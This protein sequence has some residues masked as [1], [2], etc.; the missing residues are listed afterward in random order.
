MKVGVAGLW[1]LGTV[2]AACCA[3][4]GHAVV[5]FDD[6][7]QVVNNLRQN[8]LPVDEPGLAELTR[9]EVEAGRLRFTSDAADLSESEVLWIAYDTPVNEEDVADVEYVNRRVAT[10]LP[11]LRNGA[12]VLISSQL[13]VGSTS[14][15]GQRWPELRFAY[16]P[17]NLRLGKAI[18]VFTKPD[19]VVVG[20]RDAE[21][22]ERL[23]P[24]F[25]PFTNKIEWMSIESAEMTKH[26]LNAFL[27]LSVTFINEVATICEKTGADAN[28]VE[29]GLKTDI[30]I[31][32]R[33]YLHAGSA[34]AG[35]TLARD[36]SFLIDVGE[37]RKIPTH[38]LQGARASNAEHKLWDRRLLSELLG[39]VDGKSVAILGLTYKPG[40][41][42]LRRSSSVETSRWLIA[43]GAAV[44]AF[45]P[46][47]TELP[48][49]L[50]AVRLS[51]SAEGALEGADAALIATPW[52]ELKAIP[53]AAFEKKMRRPLVL[54]PARHLEEVLKGEKG[55]EYFGIGASR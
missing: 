10:L 28:E 9:R 35:G 1:H 14:R 37:D 24:L 39:G 22:R 3:S 44:S 25:A 21:S 46:A 48:E 26:A 55:V 42:T 45:D 34:F 6:D 51:Q 12:L 38:L 5:A 2:T 40:T 36:L 52:P 8:K 11:H 33:A 16:S 23:T 15:L 20:V 32:S 43:Q 50:R 13:P 18:E 30:R 27:A 41:N 47:I 4:A 31:G 49:E 17:E 29:R 19:R 53:P 7:G 54:D